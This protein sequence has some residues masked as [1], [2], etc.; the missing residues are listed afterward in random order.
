MCGAAAVALFTGAPDHAEAFAGG[1]GPAVVAGAE[2]TDGGGRI[3]ARLRQEGGQSAKLSFYNTQ[4]KELLS[5]GLDDGGGPEIRLSSPR[6]DASPKLLVRLAGSNDSAQIVFRD[7]TGRDRLVMG[8]DPN[9]PTED[10]F[11]VYYEKSGKQKSV[12]GDL[13]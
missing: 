8:L 12:F 5:L 13:P 7:S 11:L 3:Y 10:P 2:F 4:G 6:Q 9:R 1:A